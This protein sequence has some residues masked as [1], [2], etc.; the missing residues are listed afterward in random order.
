MGRLAVFV[1]IPLSRPHQGVAELAIY[2]PLKPD[3]HVLQGQIRDFLLRDLHGTLAPGPLLDW[4]CDA[5]ED[6][7][8]T[9][10]ESIVSDS[11]KYPV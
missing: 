8:R 4:I 1:P 2:G 6:H 3:P 9:V 11:N 10:R 5:A 7:P